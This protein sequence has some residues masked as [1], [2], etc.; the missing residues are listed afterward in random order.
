MDSMRA[1]LTEDVKKKVSEEN[2]I[3]VIIPGGLTKILQHL[4][5][6]VNKS[7]KTNLR[8]IWESW[9]TTGEHSFIRTGKLRRATLTNAAEWVF[10]AWKDVT[11]ICIINGFR[12]AEIETPLSIGTECNN[13]E[14]EIENDLPY[15]IAEQFIS[16]TEDDQFEGFSDDDCIT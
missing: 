6:L 10:Q 15:E 12:N 2:T 8:Q 3:P 9:M 4:D 7:F 1:H 11:P 16:N 14:N 13:S 5:I